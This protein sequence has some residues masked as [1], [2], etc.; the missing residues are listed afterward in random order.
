MAEILKFW[1][2]DNMDESAPPDKYPDFLHRIFP[3]AAAVNRAFY[4]A[5]R[6]E[7]PPLLTFTTGKRTPATLEKFFLSSPQDMQKIRRFVVRWAKYTVRNDSNP[8]Q[9]RQSF[10]NF[11]VHL[12]ALAKILHPKC[13]VEVHEVAEQWHE[14]FFLEEI[15]DSDA[16]GPEF[17]HCT[18]D[19]VTGDSDDD[20]SYSDVE[21]P[22]NI[23]SSAKS[24]RITRRVDQTVA[25]KE[26]EIGNWRAGSAAIT[27]TF[28]ASGDW[29]Q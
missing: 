23:C 12:E 28:L 5:A 26:L 3:P 15:D 2:P 11:K 7:L 14:D 25:V 10:Y 8:P 29:D 1:D 24:I 9:L 6:A 21:C 4:A 17:G 13:I 16:P 18:S 27:T 19:V 20:A 22:E